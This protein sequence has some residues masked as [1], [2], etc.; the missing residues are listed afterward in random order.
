MCKSILNFMIFHGGTLA[1]LMAVGQ[2]VQRRKKPGNIILFFLLICIS[3]FLFY[4]GLLVTGLVLKY[5]G[6][7]LV[8]IPVYYFIAPLFV[9]FLQS[10]STR[11]F[12]LKIVN[13]YHFLP[14][15]AVLILLM[16]FY[17]MEPSLKVEFLKDPLNIDADPT[18]L[19]LRY[20]IIMVF[21]IITWIIYY[22]YF[23]IKHSYMF[24]S[25]YRKQNPLSQYAIICFAL[26]F[27]VIT[28][29]VISLML[30][31]VFQYPY[32]FHLDVVRIFSLLVVMILFVIY[33]MGKRYPFYM[34]LLQ[35]EVKRIHYDRSK[36]DNLDIDSVLQ[37]LN[38]LVEEEKIYLDEDLNLERL[39]HELSIAPYQLSEILNDKLDS[40]FYDYINGFRIRESQQVLIDEPE[41]SIT[42]IAYS[43]GFNSLSAF[44]S[45]FS[46]ISGTNP[47][48]FREKNVK[49]KKRRK[50]AES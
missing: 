38:R 48:K 6:T 28:F 42:S 50:A 13:Y 2:L 14:G 12:I 18:G 19:K 30:H 29:Y 4:H 10:I 16:P 21:M 24:T 26:T 7:G 8:V 22:M 45:W 27:M 3:V 11:N 41:R 47:K 33:L 31:K 44:Y 1:L 46:K 40:G 35:R 20:S 39:A 49:T 34:Q 5:P 25:R 15:V 43:V 37:L 36:I 32:S 9:F 23:L 17:A